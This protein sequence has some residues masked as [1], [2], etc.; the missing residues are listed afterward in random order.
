MVSKHRL[1]NL[2][3]GVDAD[4]VG[5]GGELVAVLAGCQYMVLGKQQ[6]FVGFQ[7]LIRVPVVEEHIEAIL[8]SGENSRCSCLGLLRVKEVVVEATR[9][10]SRGE[11]LSRKIKVF[12]SNK[13]IILTFLNTVC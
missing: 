11:L 10:A 6:A 9:V 13:Y 1:I 8:S 12:H 2:I 4:L 5:V 7:F 3:G